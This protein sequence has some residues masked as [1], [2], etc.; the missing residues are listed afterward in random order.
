MC[1]AASPVFAIWKFNSVGPWA[2]T[3]FTTAVA[4]NA[5]I[6]EIANSGRWNVIRWQGRGVF[7]SSII[8]S[9]NTDLEII[10]RVVD[11]CGDPASPSKMV[12]IRYSVETSDG[13]LL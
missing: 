7:S 10:W 13:T 5:S 8:P 6:Q 4:K 9:D 1:D 3:G 11:L 12:K 2:E